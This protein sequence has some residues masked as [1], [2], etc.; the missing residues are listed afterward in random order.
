MRI[1]FILLLWE[2]YLLHSF[3]KYQS[4]ELNLVSAL[5]CFQGCWLSTYVYFITWC[6]KKLWNFPRK[7]FRCEEVPAKWSVVEIFAASLSIWVYGMCF[8]KV[9]LKSLFQ[10]YFIRM[11]SFWKPRLSHVNCKDF[12]RKNKITTI[13]KNT[14]DFRLRFVIPIIPFLTLSLHR[15]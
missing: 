11:I 10:K 7:S 2:D 5:Y 4:L 9:P 3:L 1:C 13:T 14:E 12:R 8:E 6:C 15:L